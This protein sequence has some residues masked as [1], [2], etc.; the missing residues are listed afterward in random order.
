MQNTC[1]CDGTETYGDQDC[2]YCP[3]VLQISISKDGT[4]ILYNL[5]PA[6]FQNLIE[7]YYAHLPENKLHGVKTSALVYIGMHS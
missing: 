6:T 1:D 3:F 4:L 5:Y 2:N 7:H